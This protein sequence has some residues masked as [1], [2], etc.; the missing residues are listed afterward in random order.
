[1]VRQNVGTC[2]KQITLQLFAPDNSCYNEHSKRA[3]HPSTQR[4]LQAASKA[5]ARLPKQHECCP[6]T[7]QSYT[8]RLFYY[9]FLPLRMVAT[10]KP[11]AIISDSAWKTLIGCE[12]F[13][14]ILPCS[15]RHHLI[16]KRQPPPLKPLACLAYHSL[17]DRYW[18]SMTVFNWHTDW[19]CLVE[20]QTNT[21]SDSLRHQRSWQEVIAEC[22]I[23]LS[24]ARPYA[25]ST[26]VYVYLLRLEPV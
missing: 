19:S 5:V 1:M 8:G 6:V 22:D 7:F 25:D 26:H 10:S 24:N 15:H 23:W 18:F 9:F 20:N 4:S 11:N 2:P 12:T 13:L 21:Q 16:G 14:E 3:L 17:L